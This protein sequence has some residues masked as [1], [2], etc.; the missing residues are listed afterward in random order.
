MSIPLIVT[1]TELKELDDVDIS[2]DAGRPSRKRQRL[3]PMNSSD[4]AIIMTRGTD[5]VPG[6]QID[7]L[8]AP[9]PLASFSTEALTVSSAQQLEQQQQQEQQPQHLGQRQ[10]QQNNGRGRYV[11]S[12]ADR[13]K[14]IPNDQPM[15]RT[16]TS[17]IRRARGNF[18]SQL[19]KVRKLMK[20]MKTLHGI[21]ATF[22]YLEN[23]TINYQSNTLSLSPM[24]NLI[25][26]N[27][28]QLLRQILHGTQD[29][30]TTDNSV[31][32]ANMSVANVPSR[33]LKLLC[34]QLKELYMKH[35]E[36][37][38]VFELLQPNWWPQDVEWNER[39]RP[40]TLTVCKRRAYAH[41]LLSHLVTRSD[42]NIH[43]TNLKS[44]PKL[45]NPAHLTVHTALSTCKF[46]QKSGHSTQQLMDASSIIMSCP[47]VYMCDL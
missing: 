38:A 9:D 35:S 19:R 10:Q 8:N 24:T 44:N 43:L 29:P 17:E 3:D 22:I 47:C 31:S 32:V 27:E 18:A 6:D 36:L 42:G 41:S 12:D 28:G 39:Y 26:K 46:Q 20:D 34:T 11:F 14:R 23:A 4:S 13:R 33:S 40:S 21:S 15:P 45:N 5:G 25:K 7:Q 30:N 16:T 2:A 1:T 37:K